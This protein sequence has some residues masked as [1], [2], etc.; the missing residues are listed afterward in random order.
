MLGSLL[1]G[2]CKVYADIRGGSLERGRQDDSEL[3]NNGDFRC[4][5]SLYFLKF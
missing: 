4:F 1:S 3:V 2:L 5:R